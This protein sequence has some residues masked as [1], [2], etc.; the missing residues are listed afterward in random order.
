LKLFLSYRNRFKKEDKKFI[1]NDSHPLNKND[2]SFKKM[3][4]ESII[5]NKNDKWTFKNKSFKQ[6]TTILKEEKN[7][8]CQRCS[9]F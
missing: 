5:S 1:Q 4:K 8:K 3:V 7:S 2:I 9:I 6:D